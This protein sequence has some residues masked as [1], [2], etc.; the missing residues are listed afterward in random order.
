MRS[1]ATR[2]LTK[3]E[4]ENIAKTRLLRAI[5]SLGMRVRNSR[6]AKVKVRLA[7]MNVAGVQNIS[8]TE[9][10]LLKE[11]LNLEDIRFFDEVTAFAEAFVQ[12]DARKVGPRLGSKVQ[13]VIRAG[14]EGKFRQERDGSITI[15][16]GLDEVLSPDE[17]SIT[18]RARNNDQAD[19]ATQEGIV[20][21]IDFAMQQTNRESFLQADAR[22]IIRSIQATRKQR[23]LKLSDQITI[24]TV[25]GGESSDIK[26]LQDVVEFYGALIEDE[27]HG[28]FSENMNDVKLHVKFHMDNGK[29]VIDV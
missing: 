14:K 21:Q 5:V 6:H 4:H 29:V 12:V 18:Y 20:V 27:T 26:W 19:I 28:K 23:G 9:K 22:N 10:M 16:D 15:L 13:E 17:A 3:S 8:D 25:E 2:E 11:E 7:L 24:E 1:P